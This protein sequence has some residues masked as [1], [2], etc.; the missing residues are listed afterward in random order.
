MK[1]IKYVLGALILIMYSCTG[2]SQKINGVS[3]VSSGKA[4]TQKNV[5]PLIE[6]KANYA[7][8]M[9]FGF[10]R[11]ISDPKLFFNEKRQWF[12]ERKEGVKQY[13][14][15]LQKNNIK[16]MMK[17][18]IWIAKGVYTG[19]LKMES[20]AQWKQLESDYRRFILLYAEVAA[21]VDAEILCIGT[22]LEQFVAHRPQYWKNLIKEI[23]QIYKGKL[24]YAANWDEYKRTPFWG[25]LDYI[26]ID[27][28]YPVAT[29]KTPTI[30]ECREGWQRWK[31]EIKQV[32][33]RHQKQILFTEF[34]YRSVDY[35][36]KEPW[37]S[38]Y[39]MTQVNLA[40]QTQATE[41]LFEEFWKEEWF[42]GG[43]VWKWFLDYENSGGAENARFTPQNKPVEKVIRSYFEKF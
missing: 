1:S 12:G 17:P 40:A 4:V 42:A 27:G 3:F 11:S 6:L 33:E 14:Q 18:Q 39:S 22:E 34:G 26:G 38:D 15:M 43:F 29:T 7:A 19:F 30:E 23:K 13:M 41:A 32:A 28:Y 8:V 2:Q 10:I 16:I 20:E 36:A 9:P 24:T 21:E 5:D 25:A 31:P 37:K 35:T